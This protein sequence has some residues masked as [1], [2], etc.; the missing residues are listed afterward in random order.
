MK[1]I[2]LI[3]SFCSI[4]FETSAQKSTLVFRAPHEEVTIRIS[5][6]IDNMFNYHHISDKLDLKPNI[7]ISYEL[8]VNDFDF[9]ECEFSTGDRRVFLVMPGDRL[10]ITC[11]PQ[12]VAISGSNTEGQLYYNE[13]YVAKGLGYYWNTIGPIFEQYLANLPIQWDSIGYY[14]RQKMIIPYQ[15]DLK[16]MEL[17]GSITP[18]FTSILAK[19]LYFACTLSLV[20]YC[21]TLLRGLIHKEFKPSQEDIR[22]TLSLL[23]QFYDTPYALS[24]KLQKMPYYLMGYLNLKY[25]YMDEEAKEKLTE[26]YD[27]DCFG[28]YAYILLASDSLQLRQYGTLFIENLLSGTEYFNH[29]KM[30]AYLS[31]KFPD[32]EYVAIIKKMMGQQVSEEHGEII[33]I[34]DSISSF[35]ELL[36]LPGIKGKYAYIDLW[37]TSCMPCVFEFQYNDDVHEVLAAYNNVVPIYISIDKDREL[38]KSRVMK[39]QLKGYNIMASNFLQEDI[40]I[41]I[42]KENKVGGIPR[43]F[44]VDPEGNIVNDNLPRPRKSTQLK[45]ILDGALK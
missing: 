32:S 44:L 17:S 9:V 20:M 22:N 8:D 25:K 19:D 18:K 33:I 2:Y 24:G 14:F 7:S 5:K 38:W 29:K 42:Y 39:Y 27:K 4:L 31:T 35:K 21:E 41:R 3:F 28:G 13:N 30:L 43:Y 40:G 34:N 45:T 26:G 15:V 11:E 36:Q 12:K 16:K 1:H 10:E 23:S 6:S 37:A